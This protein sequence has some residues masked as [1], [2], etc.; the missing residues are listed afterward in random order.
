MYKNVKNVYRKFDHGGTLKLERVVENVF[1]CMYQCYLGS[2]TCD[3][4][5]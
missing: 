5:A 1:L 4:K 3:Y 2:K